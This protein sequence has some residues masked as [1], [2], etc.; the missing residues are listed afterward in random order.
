MKVKFY[1]D[2]KP[3]VEEGGEGLHNSG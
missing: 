1:S 2:E 3:G